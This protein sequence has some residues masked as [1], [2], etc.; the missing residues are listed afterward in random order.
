MVKVVGFDLDNTLFDQSTYEFPVFEKIAALTAQYYGIDEKQYFSAMQSL[1][2]ENVKSDLFGKAF[3]K[4]SEKPSDWESFVVQ[5]ILPVYR[6]YIPKI[7]TLTSLG[8][9]LLELVQTYDVKIVLIT[10][11]RVK[12]QQSKLKA[13]GLEEFFDLLLISDQYLPVERK[14]S[15]H[16]FTETLKYFNIS[17]EEMIFIGDDDLRDGACQKVAVPYFPVYS[18]SLIED[19]TKVLHA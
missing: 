16:M 4:V 12:T 3:M 11:G 19:L 10:N 7:L 1:Y 13:L 17:A 9:V 5:T 14:P 18:K 15:T 8:Q 6:K 2:Y